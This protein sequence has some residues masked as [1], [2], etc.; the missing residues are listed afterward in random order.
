[1]LPPPCSFLSHAPG[2]LLSFPSFPSPARFTSF[3]ISPDP[4]PSALLVHSCEARDA[5]FDG[6][7]CPGAYEAARD[8][9]S[10]TRLAT[11][12]TGHA[13]P[14]SLNAPNGQRAG[15][16]V[17][18]RTSTKPRSGFRNRLGALLPRSSA[19]HPAV[20]TT[21]VSACRSGLRVGRGAFPLSF[22]FLHFIAGSPHP[23]HSL[24]LTRLTIH[25]AHSL[26]HS[27]LAQCTSLLTLAPLQFALHLTPRG[28]SSARIR[29]PSPDTPSTFLSSFLPC[30]LPLRS[31]ARLQR[32]MG[33]RSLSKNRIKMGSD[34]PASPASFASNVRHGQSVDLRAT[35][36]TA[37]AQ[38]PRRHGEYSACRCLSYLHPS[39]L[40]SGEF[41]DYAVRM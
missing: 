11:I 35:Q 23:P 20:T 26:S 12:H 34:S 1:M 18:Q 5:A 2:R 13:T 39:Y 24:V 27:Q 31:L 28:L 16:Q 21:T 9:H 17:T 33:V 32:F 4:R 30:S 38:A 8:S 22:P 10:R 25:S 40:D 14:S 37:P 36:R 29:P 15:V 7:F 19:S 6:G 3:D 41:L